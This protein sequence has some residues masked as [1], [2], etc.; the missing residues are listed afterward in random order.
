MYSFK[1]LQIHTNTRK[2]KKKQLNQTTKNKLEATL[3]QT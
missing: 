1:I 2:N 3:K